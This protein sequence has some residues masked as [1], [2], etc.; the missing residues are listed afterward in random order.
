MG[1]SIGEIGPGG[2]YIFYKSGNEFKEVVDLPTSASWNTAKTLT[3]NYRGGGF[4]NWYLPDIGELNLIYSNLHSKDMGDL[5]DWDYWSSTEYEGNP[6]LGAWYFALDDG[7]QSYCLKT[8]T[9]IY[10]CAVRR[11]TL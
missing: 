1:Y 6:T 8:E 9:D 4:S 10:V 11:F 7:S 3:A 2:G 5:Y